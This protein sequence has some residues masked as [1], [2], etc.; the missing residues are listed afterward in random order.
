ML[1]SRAK[2]LSPC[3]L[4]ALG[5]SASVLD[6]GCGDMILTEHLCRHSELAITA[7]DTVDSNLSRLS[8]TLY[9]GTTIPFDTAAFDA[10]IAVFVLHHCT[11]VEPILTEIKR[12]TAKKIVILE[13]IYN[14]FYAKK[15]LQLH[16]FGNKFLSSKMN[17]PL[18][19]L[20]IE[21]WHALFNKIDLKLVNC[22]RIYQYRRLNL[23]HQM[24]FEL[25]H[26]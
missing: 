6:F 18:N 1:K 11:E 8:L 14:G 19:F 17:I 22:T 13:E 12:V 20:K 24:M 23:T 4:Q 3:I 5:N 16:D 10:A 25:E 9:S 7:L 21:E 2:Q 26:P 15:L